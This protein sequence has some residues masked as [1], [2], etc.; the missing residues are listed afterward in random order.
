MKKAR[1]SMCPKVAIVSFA[2][3]FAFWLVYVLAQWFCVNFTDPEMDRF[4]RNAIDNAMA[5][6]QGKD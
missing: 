3:A 6:W 5:R 2:C 4:E 1:P